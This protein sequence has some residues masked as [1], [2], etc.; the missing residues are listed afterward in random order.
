MDK[1]RKGLNVVTASYDAAGSLNGLDGAGRNVRYEL[2]GVFG[3]AKDALTLAVWLAAKRWMRSVNVWTI[4]ARGDAGQIWHWQRHRTEPFW[5]TAEGEWEASGAHVAVIE[6][7]LR[8]KNAERTQGV[9]EWAARHHGPM[10]YEF[11]DLMLYVAIP[12]SSAPAADVGVASAEP[13]EPPG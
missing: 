9:Q 11:D 5:E 8:D 2:A 13:S 3:G 1:W 10:A 4:H 6:L 7:W 12:V